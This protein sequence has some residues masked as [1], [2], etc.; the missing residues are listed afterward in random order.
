MYLGLGE[1]EALK[2]LSWVMLMAIVHI[3]TKSA[4]GL[5]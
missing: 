5:T 2:N 1:G 3:Q 4:R